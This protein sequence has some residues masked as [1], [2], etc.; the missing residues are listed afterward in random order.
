MQLKDYKQIFRLAELHL[1]KIHGKIYCPYRCGH[2]IINTYNM[3]ILHG[4]ICRKTLKCAEKD[5][6]NGTIR[7]FDPASDGHGGLNGGGYSTITCRECYGKGY[8]VKQV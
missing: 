6:S 5:C 1:E 4:R 3:I 8:L 2:K 7:F